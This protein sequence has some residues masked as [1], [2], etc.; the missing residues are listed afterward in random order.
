MNKVDFLLGARTRRDVIKG[1]GITTLTAICGAG[2]GA[3]VSGMAGYIKRP[4]PVGMNPRA[5]AEADR[6]YPPIMTAEFKR[7]SDWLY[8]CVKS[9]IL[10][11]ADIGASF[12]GAVGSGMGASL[13]KHA[14]SLQQQ[15]AHIA[16]GLLTNGAS[17]LVMEMS[18]NTPYLISLTDIEQAHSQW[19]ERWLPIKNPSANQ[20]A[21][22]KT[23]SQVLV[24]MMSEYVDRIKTIAKIAAGAGLGVT[25]LVSPLLTTGFWEKDENKR[26][27]LE[28]QVTLYGKS[29]SSL[30]LN[31]NEEL[32]KEHPYVIRRGVQ[33]VELLQALLG[34]DQTA[35]FK[36]KAVNNTARVGE[37]ALDSVIS[38]A[39]ERP[40]ARL[41]SLG[42]NG[43]LEDFKEH[44]ILADHTYTIER[45]KEAKKR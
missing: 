34:T 5:L 29:G 10:L 8:A 35:S 45:V 18:K 37:V 3:L 32:D 27:F 30:V 21:D 19:S 39:K 11:G 43:K 44:R 22:F 25:G 16:H 15:Q 12:A 6:N 28:D 42:A 38:I 40:N 26:S 4:L 17:T 9:S 23:E 36:V 13:E 1:L 31:T 41:Y 2:G 20:L 7:V 14:N 24:K 33:L